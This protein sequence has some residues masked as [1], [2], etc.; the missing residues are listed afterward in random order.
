MIQL[1][2]RVECSAHS[3][4][5][6][7]ANF[8]SH[9]NFVIP[10]YIEHSGSLYS[11]LVLIDSSGAAGNIIDVALSQKLQLPLHSLE[12]PLQLQALDSGC[13]GTLKPSPFIFAHS[14]LVTITTNSPVVLGFPWMHTH[15]PQ[16]LLKEH[17]ITCWPA[18]CH[19]NCL[20]F[21]SV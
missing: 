13:I 12:H 17:Q 10:V 8:L 11:V 15:D 9:H 1:A 3:T 16:I 14:L 5:V 21:P 18:H 7:P 4:R 6:S 20:H 2:E 19:V